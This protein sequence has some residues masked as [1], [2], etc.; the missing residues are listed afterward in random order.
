MDVVYS[1]YDALV[2]IN[3]PDEKAKAVI[4]A[5]E[6]EMMDKLATR[7]DLT[8]LRE[9]VSRDLEAM[10]TGA[11]HRFAEFERKF[12]T[13]DHKLKELESRLVFKVGVMTAASLVLTCTVLGTLLAALR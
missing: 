6:R 8:H 5:L 10:N 4:D 12:E 3:V 13:F 2:S 9:M 1:L 11:E 7:S